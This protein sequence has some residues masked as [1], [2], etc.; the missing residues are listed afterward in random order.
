THIVEV[1]LPRLR[2]V[3]LL[4]GECAWKVIVRLFKSVV[5]SSTMSEPERLANVN[6]LFALLW[7][8]ILSSRVRSDKASAKTATGSLDEVLASNSSDSDLGIER[9]K[10]LYGI[11]K[12][13]VDMKNKLLGILLLDAPR[14][15]VWAVDEP[16]LLSLGKS[17]L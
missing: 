11:I 5:L 13:G 12:A 2:D 6:G 16:Q 17:D 7:S 10:S 4:V 8:S 1:I 14:T 15:A 9:E 3:S